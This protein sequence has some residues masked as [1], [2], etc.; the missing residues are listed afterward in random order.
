MSRPYSLTQAATGGLALAALFL[1]APSARAQNAPDLISAVRRSNVAAVRAWLATHEAT[2]TQP[3]GSTALHWAANLDNLEIAGLLLAHGA[4]VDAA[5][6]FGITPLSL[7]ATNGSA[8]MIERLLEAGANPNLELPT[9]ETPLMTAARTGDTGSVAALLAHHADPNAAEWELGQTALMWAVAEGHAGAAAELL[10]HGARV[11]TGSSSGFTALMFAARD[12]NIEIAR[13]LLKAGAPIDAT[14]YSG[15]TALSVAVVRGQVDLAEFLLD[16]HA[17]P[18]IDEA[19]YTA[20]HWAVARW[21]TG[22]THD[23][24]E[25]RGEWA[26]LGGIPAPRQL[27]M[28]KALLHH[29][30]DPNARARK[31]PPRF[32]V[33]LF[34][35]GN[36]NGATPFYFAAMS[37]DVDVL[38][39]LIANGADPLIRVA[40]G[41]SPLMMAC[42]Q[43]RTEGE[44][45]ITDQQSRRAAEYIVSVGSGGINTANNQGDTALHSAATQ[46]LDETIR[47]LVSTGA[48][49]QLKNKKGETPLK[50]AEGVILLAQLIEHPRT[51]DVIRSLGGTR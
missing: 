25:A 10:E 24:A 32:G 5:T 18:N 2:V 3:D 46:G 29:G 16:Q 39:L 1:T 11:E 6:D 35:P 14:S 37:A 38:R 51:A 40:D 42:G 17:N 27:E 43:G 48:D 33:Y 36:L 7:A 8:P 22:M 45:A 4:A 21:E 12:G 34:T 9:G 41:T 13:T 23:Y 50:V 31:S 47:F 20:L 26:T 44:S 49:L 28:I 15:D 19:G 30:A